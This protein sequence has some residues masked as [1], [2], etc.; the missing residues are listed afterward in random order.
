M[1][2]LNTLFAQRDLTGGVIITCL[3]TED[4]D[5]FCLVQSV[6]VIFIDLF[7]AILCLF[8]YVMEAQDCLRP[9]DIYNWCLFSFFSCFADQVEKFLQYFSGKI[10]ATP[11]E[12]ECFAF[13]CSL[14]GALVD[15]F[16][17]ESFFSL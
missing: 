4:I 15:I 13:L 5:P 9:V 10:A 8:F 16:V 2:F 12:G 1:H 3:K 6:P 14:Q 17:K 7:D 11:V